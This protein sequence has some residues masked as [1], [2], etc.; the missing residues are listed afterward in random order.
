ME[1]E[2]GGKRESRGEEK[3]RD[4][5]AYPP[6]VRGELEDLYRELDDIYRDLKRRLE[7][8]EITAVENGFCSELKE[9]DGELP[10]LQ[11][12]DLDLPP[13][14]VR[15][16]M[17]SV[18]AG[19]KQVVEEDE[20]EDLEEFAGSLVKGELEIENLLY[21]YLQGEAQVREDDDLNLSSGFFYRIML[22]TI[23]P[24]ISWLGE[25]AEAD[26]RLADTWQQQ[27]CPVC[28]AVPELSRLTHEQGKRILYCWLCGSE[29]RFERFT[30]PYCGES[31]A[32]GQKYF[33]VENTPYRVDIC[34][35]CGDYIKVI[36]ER[37]VPEGKAEELNWL[38]NDLGTQHLDRL[39]RKEGYGQKNM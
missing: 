3:S 21:R 29:W 39:A 6:R 31:Q 25:K 18:I 12:E 30:C 9:S 27:S 5:P 35:D 28:G 15:E 26:G 34:Q 1:E 23:R 17:L 33:V 37:R 32:G 2:G 8:G 13:D 10:L 20:R 19:L 38:I 36:D 24:Y 4:M 22:F 16:T 14:S 7:K 11:P